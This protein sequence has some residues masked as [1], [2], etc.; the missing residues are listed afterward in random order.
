[1]FTI[2]ISEKGGAERRETFD[3]NEISVGRVQGNDLM[4]PKGNVSKHHARLLF[5]DGR[6]IVTDLKSTNGTYVNGRKIS[7]ATIV[8]EGDKI[9]IGDFVL[10]VETGQGRRSGRRRAVG[11]SVGR[12]PVPHASAVAGRPPCGLAVAPCRRALASR[13]CRRLSPRRCRRLGHRVAAA[14]PIRRTSATFPSSAIRTARAPRT[15]VASRCRPCRVL[16][17]SRNR[18]IRARACRRPRCSRR[19]DRRRL[20]GCSLRR[21]RWRWPQRPRGQSRRGSRRRESSRRRRP[22]RRPGAWPSSRS[23]HGCRTRS[24]SRALDERDD[25][26]DALVEAIERTAREQAKVVRA[27]GE[28]PEGFDAELLVRDAVA[29]I[30]GP[31]TARRAGSTTT[32]RPRSTSQSAGLRPR[33]AR[34]ASCRSPSRVHERGR[35]SSA[36]W[37]ASAAAPGNRCAPTR[38]SSSAGWPA[39]RTSWPSGRRSPRRGSSPSA[40]RAASKA[41]STTWYAPARC[42]D[43]WPS[44]SRPASRREGQRAGRRAGAGARRFLRRGA[45]AAAPAGDRIVLLQDVDEIVG[46]ARVRHSARRSPTRGPTSDPSPRRRALG[47]DRLVIASLG[48]PLVAATL[49]AIADGAEGVVA[50]VGAPSL[51]QGLGRL[52]AHVA[53]SRPG[54]S[55]EAAREAIGESFDLAVEIGRAASDGPSAGPAR[56]RARGRG[57]EG[58]RDARPLRV[59]SGGRRGAVRRDGHDASR[60]RET[61]PRAACASTR[62]CS[63][64]PASPSR[65]GVV[66]TA[67][68]RGLAPSAPEGAVSASRTAQPR[69]ESVSAR[70]GP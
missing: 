50:G 59:E 58:R 10:R 25:P 31:R 14:C 67:V 20:R 2:V 39:A 49:D 29:E 35:R 28:A 21:C 15:S 22:I 32:R 48:G 70:C 4:L 52:A 62:R 8:R 53:L 36:R 16:R 65:A 45:L 7:Q 27:Q 9:Y 44:S 55:L 11:G 6:F 43:R 61:S 18:S 41:R 57:R 37:S 66:Q 54:V 23:S 47:A 12:R 3:K 38:R 69:A 40:S 13:G 42:R 1:M 64:A 33:F 34:R 17:A 63:S 46:A 68:A 19:V 51:R 60:S 26:P 5:R 24:I 30:A 56:R